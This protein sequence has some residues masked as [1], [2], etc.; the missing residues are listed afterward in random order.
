VYLEAGNVDENDLNRL[1]RHQSFW[2]V[3]I[4]AVGASDELDAVPGEKESGLGKYVRALAVGE[5]GIVILPAETYRI[6]G[7]D[8]DFYV[9]EQDQ[10]ASLVQA[11]V[12]FP[13]APIPGARTTLRVLDGTGTPGAAFTVAKDLAAENGEIRALGN[14][15]SFDYVGTQVLYY[16]RQHEEAAQDVADALGAG[17]VEFQENPDEVVM[18]TVILGTDVVGGLDP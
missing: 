3:W 4:D 9:P 15:P 11:M 13:A 18:V 2:E 7:V 6:P 12:P 17:S 5:A 1:Q 8:E 10:L 14:G 16:D